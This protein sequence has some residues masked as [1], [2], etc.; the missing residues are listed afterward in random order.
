MMKF[1]ALL[2]AFA[3]AEIEGIVNIHVGSPT[4]ISSPEYPENM[5]TQAQVSWTVTS[6]P[7]FNI[8]IEFIEFFLPLSTQCKLLFLS[9]STDS[10]D[11][12][13]ISN[14]F[15]GMH[16]KIFIVDGSQALLYLRADSDPDPMLFKRFKLK[17]S[18]TLE[19]PSNF[20]PN[21]FAGKMENPRQN[22]KQPPVAPGR[23]MMPMTPV[24]QQ[25]PLVHQQATAGAFGA[26]SNMPA[27]QFGPQNFQNYGPSGIQQ[28]QMPV[29]QV[30]PIS[31]QNGPA[32]PMPAGQQNN[33][34]RKENK[35]PMSLIIPFSVLTLAILIGASAFL[36][37]NYLRDD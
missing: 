35:K 29:Q 4:I 31:A 1:L 24:Q 34:L 23:P 14:R 36:I 15:C 32:P 28:R 27:L 6:D 20:A 2:C 9:I 13:M 22:K 12:N 16:P 25:L 5:P 17:V 11:S 30:A 33:N 7:G 19:R 8:K 3:N 18:K 21:T 26:S 10:D 37:K